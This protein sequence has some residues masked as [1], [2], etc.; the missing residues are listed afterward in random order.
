MLVLADNASGI[1]CID[2]FDKIEELDRMAI[3]KVMELQTISIL[4]AGITTMLNVLI[5]WK[6]GSMQDS[7]SDRQEDRDRT[8]QNSSGVTA[9]SC[10]VLST[11]SCG[12][13]VFLLLQGEIGLHCWSGLLTV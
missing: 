10:G 13:T 2:E 11:L 3:H 7:G 6:R 5:C 8:D 4:K 9:T 12:S 1:C